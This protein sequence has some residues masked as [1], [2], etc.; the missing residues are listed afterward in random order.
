MSLPK[1]ETCSVYLPP[2][3]DEKFVTMDLRILVSCDVPSEYTAVNTPS[4]TSN[5]SPTS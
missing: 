4:E 2:F 3:S 5:S 1:Y